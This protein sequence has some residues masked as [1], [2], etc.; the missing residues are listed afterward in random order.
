MR[1]EAWQIEM[2]RRTAPD[3]AAFVQ[4]STP[5]ISFGAVMTAEVATIGINPSRRE[6]DHNGRLTGANRRLATMESL[7][8]EPGHPLT[9]EQARQVVDDC[10]HYFTRNPYWNGSSDSTSC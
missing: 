3:V 1:V 7:A 10:N 8:A 6:F 4:G 5:V 9:D 2:A